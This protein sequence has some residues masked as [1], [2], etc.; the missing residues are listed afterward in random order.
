[1]RLDMVALAVR[2][3]PC[4]ALD[5]VAWLAV[6]RQPFRQ[7]LSPSA[8]S[9]SSFVGATLLAVDVSALAMVPMNME[10]WHCFVSSLLVLH[11]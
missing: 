7:L 6:L 9:T 3:L 4:V 1:M 10:T 2:A 5:T 11:V 8:S